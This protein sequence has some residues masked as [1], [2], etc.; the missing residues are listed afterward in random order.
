[1]EEEEE[2]EEEAETAWQQVVSTLVLLETQRS[3]RSRHDPRNKR[4]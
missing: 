3:A 2:E 1:V 4:I